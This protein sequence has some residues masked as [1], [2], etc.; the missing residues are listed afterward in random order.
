MNTAEA[1]EAIP[2]RGK[3]ELLVTPILRRANSKYAAI[4]QTGINSK[5]ETIPSPVDGFCLVPGSKPN[6][7]L[8]VQHTTT[9]RS[10]LKY[11]WLNDT[12][13]DLIKASAKAQEIRKNN[14]E[15]E[16]TVI[17][18][19]NR[20]LTMTD[21]KVND[22]HPK[23]KEHDLI[24]S[25]YQKAKELN[26]EYEIWDQHRLVDFLDNTPDG[27]W[28][29]RK[30]G[31]E[32]ELLSESLLHHLCKESLTLY[33]KEIQL[34]DPTTWIPRAVNEFIRSGFLRN[35]HTFQVLVGDSG[36]GKSIAA[37]SA[38]KEHIDNNGYGL[39]V[40][41][42]FINDSISVE[43]AIDKVLHEL[44]PQLI[45]G[46]GESARRFI[47][48]GSKFILVVDDVNRTA[49]PKNIIT[50]LLNWSRPN[51]SETNETTNSQSSDFF[52]VCP[53]WPQI[54]D[55][56]QDNSPWI[57][58]VSI[59][60]MNRE[61]SLLAIGLVIKD[62]G[63]SLSNVEK[64]SIA[65]KLDNDPFLIGLFSQLIEASTSI[66]LI[67]LAEDVMER[68]INQ[69]VKEVVDCSRSYL[70]NEYLNALSK[71]CMY[72]LREKRLIPFWGEI[73][74]WFEEDQEILKILRDIIRNKKL[75]KL[76]DQENNLVFRHDRIREAFFVKSM[77][78][79]LEDPSSDK[80]ILKEPFYAEIIGK[81]IILSPQSDRLIKDLADELPLALFE[82]LKN[83]GN[84]LTAYYKM[85]VDSIKDWVNRKFASRDVLD[86]VIN[87]ICF[88]L[89]NTDS[90]AVLELTENFPTYPP[91]LLSRLRNGSAL[92]GSIYCSRDS[93]A[94]GDDLRD[95]IIEHA[96]KRHGDHLLDELRLILSSAACT[97]EV[98]KGALALAGF[99][100]FSEL[101][102][103][104]G[105]CWN[106]ANDKQQI[107]AEAVWAGSRCCNEQPDKLLGPMMK[108]LAGLSDERIS[109]IEVGPRIRISEELGIAMRRGI[110]NKV[111][112]YFSSLHEVCKPLNWPIVIMLE[113]VD[114]PD[115]IELCVRFA[116]KESK[117]F[118]ACFMLPVNW[119]PTHPHGERL[120]N[121]SL[122]R[123]MLLW[124]SL[125]TD[126][127]TKY[128]AFKIWANNTQYEQINILKEVSQSESLLYR[129]AI[130]RRAQLE[131]MSVVQQL[132]SLMSNDIH[133]FDVAHN[134]WC[135]EI[136]AVAELYLESI[137][138][139]IPGAPYY[140][141]NVISY[142]SKLLTSIPVKDSEAL[143]EKYWGHLWCIP[144]F[145]HTA[146]YIGTEK[147]LKLAN[148]GIKDC[149][150]S[151]PVF[152]MLNCTFGFSI[153]GRQEYLTKQHLERLAPYIDMFDD[154][155][156]WHLAELCQRLGIP[157]WKR[158]EISNRL[159]E[160]WRIRYYPHDDDLLLELD[161]VAASLRPDSGFLIW[162]FTHWIEEFEKRNDSRAQMI[163]E[164]WF[165]QN[166]TLKGLKIVAA[167]LIVKGTRRDL[168]LLDNYEI[169]GPKDEISRI[170]D[171]VRFSVCRRSLD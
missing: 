24:T 84:P 55:F 111:I 116:A 43:S 110:C 157:N 77:I 118:F 163:V 168:A 41:A 150:G 36:Y 27:H 132:A 143:L 99:L 160:V 57:Q 80:D 124:S 106:L 133:M 125:Q 12:D 68:F 14:P 89:M 26:L 56:N 126:E 53:L 117:S 35:K 51:R 29:R 121:P 4:I 129:M 83:F 15:A 81:A 141:D 34:S 137:K 11:K 149:P 40:P 60:P 153:T 108:F 122:D 95:Q 78:S 107:I 52:I 128:Q 166:H 42:G 20:N 93:I 65:D 105:E 135:G 19:T 146:L 30:L 39:W 75:I 139:N 82:A 7:F 165:D 90:S 138:D 142:L 148:S 136:S 45:V 17:L 123:L 120:S 48:E 63:I 38:L 88:C 46:S 58:M 100:E 131:D 167:F 170:K 145:I 71:L 79:I 62:A 33:E 5:G 127:P 94:M 10:R 54:W 162:H 114:M 21:K 6:H 112:N 59:G 140:S 171:D 134:V 76:T 47:P 73:Q 69:C 23:A 28:L 37:Y 144:K 3:F 152:K 18:T 66:D 119:D 156:L 130:R 8:F 103:E 25:T 104:I 22:T 97:D 164:R 151:I 158:E 102:D 154:D 32:A 101:E 50:R 109:D 98:R 16:F 113:H 169:D 91:I 9:E 155:V 70:E 1:L 61:E 161:N 31:I 115:A 85:I 49:E 13:G 72:M 44:H 64:E 96:K 2:D 86:S 67:R 159:S 87:S 74:R 147:S 92:S